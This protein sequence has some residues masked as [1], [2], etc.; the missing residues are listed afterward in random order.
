MQSHATTSP[1]DQQRRIPTLDGWRAIAILLV[2]VSHAGIA[3]Y[4]TLHIPHPDSLGQHGVTIFF[5]LSGFL[6]TSRF[7]QETNATGSIHLGSFYVRRFFRLM[8]CAWLYLFVMLV[9]TAHS[10]PAAYTAQELWGCLLFFR[11]YLDPTAVHAVTGHFWS[12][13]IEEQFYLVWPAFLLLGGPRRTRWIALAGAAGVALYRFAHW[14]ELM[15]VPLAGTFAT[16][17]RADAL[18][19]GCAAALFLPDLK[20]YLRRWMT[21]PLLAVL[22]A[23][24]ATYKKLIPAHEC[25]IV[26]L[27]LAVTTELT[28]DPLSRFLEWKPLAFLGTFSYSLYIW[29]QV[30][31]LGVH[32]PTSFCISIAILP[33]V[34]VSSYILIEKPLIEVGRK[35]ARRIT[36]TTT[37]KP[38]LALELAV[39][40]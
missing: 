11:N 3:L 22:I 39:A 38:E 26:A 36:G 37:P 33:V 32:K 10:H 15:Q 5:V 19:I 31:I 29:Q 13:S 20:P 1:G 40:E 21:L 17:Y 2:M 16:Q 7:V 9:G 12:L 35:L 24:M 8:P 30:F 4:S 6:I 14:T 34:A 25:I 23:C 27:L 28:A 18:L